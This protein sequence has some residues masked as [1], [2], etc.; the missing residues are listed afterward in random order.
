MRV[1]NKEIRSRR[2]RKEQTVKAAERVI[3]LQYAD[4]KVSTA[5]KPKAPAPKKAAPK[6]AKPA[7]RG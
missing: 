7:P 2:H 1:R 3:R 6:P 4:K 5:P